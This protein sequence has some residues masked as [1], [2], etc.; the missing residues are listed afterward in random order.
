MAKLDE[1]RQKRGELYEEMRNIDLNAVDDKGESR[2]L[3]DEEKTKW[4]ELDQ[5]IQKLDKDIE[6]EQR[7]VDLEEQAASRIGKTQ[8]Q[9]EEREK[10]NY[11]LLSACRMAAG[12]D[13][14]EGFYREMHQEA[15][16]EFR[17][18]VGK[19]TD[20]KDSVLVPSFVISA[21]SN[22]QREKRELTAEGGTGGDQGGVL[23]Q[24][25]KQG[26]IEALKE[27]LVARSLGINVFTNL[28]GDLSMPRE[29]SVPSANWEGETDDAAESSSAM[30]SVEMSPER[31]AAYT[32]LTRQILLQQSKDLE[33]FVEDR[34]RYA[35]MKKLETA[36]INGS[37]SGNVP[38]GV[39]NNSDITTVGIGTNGGAPTWNHII[40][41]QNAVKEENAMRQSLGYLMHTKSESKLKVTKIDAG[42]GMFVISSLTGQNVGG[43]PYKVS[44]LIP[45]NLSKGTGSNLTAIIY[46]NW[47]DVFVGQW[48]GLEITYDRISLP[49]AKAGKEA[50]VI[51]SFWD[52]AIGH[53]KS[54]AAI[55]DA[56][57]DLT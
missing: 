10:K 11:S 48:G 49:L 34:L 40:A 41:L 28:S 38:E 39:L 33:S 47:A 16:K 42:S 4:D 1:L 17:E 54:F 3:T 25:G 26:F 30:D 52:V 5:K 27:E 9:K 24:T 15:E 56:S 2:D 53:G 13:P 14:F 51:N 8:K 37:G 36:I 57:T 44:N 19:S 32:T 18:M 20:R 29:T 23:I 22:E 45:T 7:R 43:Y 35:V 31:L 6:R 46:G 12:I 21:E 55:I 50:I